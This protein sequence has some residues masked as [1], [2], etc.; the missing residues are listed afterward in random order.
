MGPA[1]CIT[2]WLAMHAPA[3]AAKAASS[4]A[5][6]TARSLKL[7]AGRV[8]AV[9]ALPS[10]ERPRT[11]DSLHPTAREAEL[12]RAVHRQLGD[13]VEAWLGEHGAGGSA[14]ELRRE[15]ARDLRFAGVAV[16]SSGE[17]DA[18]DD[19]LERAV[20]PTAMVVKLSVVAPEGD[21]GLLAVAVETTLTWLGDASLYV[22]ASE[23]GRVERL[24]EWSAALAEWPEPEGSLRHGEPL[25]FGPTDVLNNF[26]FRLTERDERGR[27]VV[28]AAWSEPSPSSS[29][30]AASWAVLAPGSGSRS[31]RVLVRGSDGVFQCYD[32]SCYT[33][34]L[35][36][37]R[38]SIEYSGFGGLLADCGGFNAS[39]L[40]RR[41]R[42][43][44]GGAEQIGAPSDEP[45]GFV[46]AWLDAPWRQA[47]SW[48]ARD[49]SLRR[50]HR[51]LQPL[52]CQLERTGHWVDSCEYPSTRDVLELVLGGG[53]GEGELR[54]EA[55]LSLFFL[56]D[57]SGDA[58]ELLDITPRLPDGAWQKG[59]C[60][61]SAPSPIKSMTPGPIAKLRSPVSMPLAPNGA[62]VSV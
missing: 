52:A 3:A 51:L 50:W 43:V 11:P 53:V 12:D 24:L 62:R 28:A 57:T 22:F 6:A 8:A 41:W 49:A 59:D 25:P 4:S 21:P 44:D 1:W 19:N 33:L 13:F 31:P 30:G 14:E 10:P 55:P 58:L 17:A 61:D 23:G 60:E 29:W 34:A 46:S 15:L 48:S 27:F 7:L 45:F 20:L 47:R 54:E 2:L 5:E 18:I 39:G 9:A 32:E 37:D 16:A 40:R 42:L 56:L 38:V 36:G 35:D 26:T